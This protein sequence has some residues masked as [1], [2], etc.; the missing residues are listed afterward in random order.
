MPSATMRRPWSS[1]VQSTFHFSSSFSRSERITSA[2]LSAG[3]PSVPAGFLVSVSHTSR[4]WVATFLQS[5]SVIVRPHPPKRRAQAIPHPPK[6][7]AQAIPIRTFIAGGL[8]VDEALELLGPARMTQ[9]TQRLG[10]DLAD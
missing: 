2:A 3:R 4:M 7:R 1:F 6:R 9:L 5:S 8:V 10:L